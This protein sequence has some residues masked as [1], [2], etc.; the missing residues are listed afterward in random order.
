MNTER[1]AGEEL[2]EK[3]RKR[4]KAFAEIVAIGPL[5]MR[6]SKFNVSL[7][8]GKLLKN[9]KSREHHNYIYFGISED[10]KKRNKIVHR[11]DEAILEDYV[12][13]YQKLEEMVREITNSNMRIFEISNAIRQFGGDITEKHYGVYNVPEFENKKVWIRTAKLME[14]EIRNQRETIRKVS[15]MSCEEFEKWK[16]RAKRDLKKQNEFRVNADGS[17]LFVPRSV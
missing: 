6:G 9:G 2:E 11:K 1:T 15:Q 8:T 17:I 14:K 3:L 12:R 16:R 13:N 4:Q 5:F 7:P 10:G